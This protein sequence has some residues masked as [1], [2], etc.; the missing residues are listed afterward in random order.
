MNPQ[1]FRCMIRALPAGICLDTITSRLKILFG[2]TPVYWRFSD[3]MSPMY[4][5]AKLLDWSRV[6]LV[7]WLMIMVSASNPKNCEK[8]RLLAMLAFSIRYTPLAM[9]PRMV[10]FEDAHGFDTASVWMPVFAVT[11]LKKA[12]F[13]EKV[14]VLRT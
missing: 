13:H 9:S 3:A 10:A 6:F 2:S 8:P 12:A 1:R 14:I 11:A 7:P 4:G 5:A